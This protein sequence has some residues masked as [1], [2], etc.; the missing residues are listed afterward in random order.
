MKL[1][2]VPNFASFQTVKISIC[3]M[4]TAVVPTIH[5]SSFFRK[6]KMAADRNNIKAVSQKRP[7][8]LEIS[9]DSCVNVPRSKAFAKPIK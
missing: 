1:A 6:N 5:H 9:L 3:E 4:I 7:I 2:R 8:G